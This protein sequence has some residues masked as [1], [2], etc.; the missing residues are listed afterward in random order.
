MKSL[1]FLISCIFLT[2]IAVASLK[3]TTLAGP[4]QYSASYKDKSAN[5]GP[6]VLS[7][8]VDFDLTS[9]MSLGVEHSRSLALSPMGTSIALTGLVARWYL[10]TPV[11]NPI[12]LN[13]T[14]QTIRI[15]Q[16]GISPYLG[17]GIGFGQA[18]VLGSEDKDNVVSLNVML[19][20]RI[21]FDYPL[22]GGLGLRAEAVVGFSIFG[23]GTTSTNQLQGGLI[24][25]F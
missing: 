8:V 15:T 21:G 23:T 10:V 2:Q 14:F 1:F 18:S 11:I 12:R 16:Q 9:R 17:A 13:E 7:V 6:L 20:P 5:E 24:Y 22:T 25:Q 3:I 19:A 4:G